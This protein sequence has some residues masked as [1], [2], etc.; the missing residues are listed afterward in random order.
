[1]KS[2]PERRYLV[3]F[4]VALALFL[5][6]GFFGVSFAFSYYA[7][8]AIRY[9]DPFVLEMKVGETLDLG[10]YCGDWRQF[11]Q[12]DDE[13]RGANGTAVAEGGIFLDEKG[14]LHA[15]RGGVYYFGVRRDTLWFPEWLS[16]TVESF[17]VVVYDAEFGDYAPVTDYGDLERGIREGERKFILKNDFTVSGRGAENVYAFRGIFVNPEGYT[18][19]IRDD[20]PLFLQLERGAVVNG[21]RLAA[22]EEGFRPHTTLNIQSELLF[23]HGL[24][25]SFNEGVISDCA[26]EADIYSDEESFV[27]AA[28]IAGVNHSPLPGT[29]NDPAGIILRCSY[30]GTAYGYNRDFPAPGPDGVYGIV[31]ENYDRGVLRGCTVRADA[32]IQGS[33]SLEDAPALAYTLFHTRINGL[34]GEKKYF[35]S[36]ASGNRIFDLSGENE[37]DLNAPVTYSVSYSRKPATEMTAFAGTLVPRDYTVFADESLRLLYITDENGEKLSVGEPVRFGEKD[38]AVHFEFRNRETHFDGQG[39]LHAASEKVAVPAGSVESELE[40][41]EFSP[42]EITLVLEGEAEISDNRGTVTAAESGVFTVNVDFSK[43]AV[44]SYAQDGSVLKKYGEEVML[45]EFGGDLT[46]GTVTLPAEATVSS[47]DPFGGAFFDRL[48]TGNVKVFYDY[49][50][51]NWVRF[52]KE[53][54]CGAALDMREIMFSSFLMLERIS[55]AAREDGFYASGGMLYEKRINEE[56]Q[57]EETALV[58]A[59]VC[60]ASGG[61]LIV[62]NCSVDKYALHFNQAQKIIFRNVSRLEEYSA[63]QAAAEE[64]AFTGA[65][66][67]LVK[68]TAFIDCKNLRSLTA[69]E[70]AGVSLQPGALSGYMKNFKTLTLSNG[71]AAVDYLAVRGNSA[72]EGYELADGCEK[73]TVENGLLFDGGYVCIPAAWKGGALAVPDGITSLH[74]TTE[75]GACTVGELLLGKDVVSLSLNNV[76]FEN[77]GIDDQNAAFAVEDGVLYTADRRTLALFPVAREGSF[78]VPDTVETIAARAFSGSAVETVYLPARLAEIGAYAFADSALEGIEIPAGVLSI[79]GNAFAGASLRTAAVGWG[80]TRIEAFTFADCEF[81]ES[82]E[83]PASLQSIGSYAF[84][85]SLCLQT[86]ELPA[87]LVSIGDHAFMQTALRSVRLGAKVETVGEGAFENCANLQTAETENDLTLYGTDA[88]AGT[89]VLENPA[90]RHGGGIYLGDAFLQPYEDADILT[91]RAGTK[92]VSSMGGFDVRR[93]D[94]PSSVEKFSQDVFADS[95]NA[96][97]EEVR[98]QTP[99][100]GDIRLTKLRVVVPA[101]VQFTGSSHSNTVFFYVGSEQ[102]Y[103]ENGRPLAHVDERTVYFYSASVPASG[104]RYWHYEAGEIAVW[105]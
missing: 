12:I 85:R 78:E 81:L 25:T 7:D 3:L 72:F 36:E 13:G 14:R 34:F 9:A 45:C 83:L 29:G 35:S 86:A 95:S 70:G 74:V 18:I 33:P 4:I 59:P 15:K 5:L 49:M 22:G 65:G 38:G 105:I 91:I 92:S 90:Y 55:A 64:F 1:M 31:A 2:K 21:L 17:C 16:M 84:A 47:G 26:A 66:G 79:G 57:A 43:S 53:I 23:S 32:Y 50:N 87:A 69:E 48:D 11:S 56:T 46:A 75:S 73:F 104:G 42:A 54:D 99:H 24:V 89:P 27:S 51:T 96:K 52:L 40:I 82:V 102:V 76:R 68:S 8:V 103:E 98:F 80:I 101:N 94:V 20:L 67:C 93:V 19:T 6:F 71:F 88:F 62:E 30:T 100:L 39:M 41:D 37:V 28:G 61:E 58:A 44:Y 97:V 10:E 63:W 77:I 60:I